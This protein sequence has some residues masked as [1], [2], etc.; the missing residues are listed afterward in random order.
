[1]LSR[2]VAHEHVLDAKEAP[3]MAASTVSNAVEVNERS[4]MATMV[5]AVFKVALSKS[6]RNQ[7]HFDPRYPLIDSS[8][9]NSYLEN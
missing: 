3:A 5:G 4:V 1:M 7:H 6:A 8:A 9:S 2:N